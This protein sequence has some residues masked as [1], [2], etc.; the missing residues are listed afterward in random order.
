M[1]NASTASGTATARNCGLPPL[2]VKQERRH[3]QQAQAAQLAPAAG[4]VKEASNRFADNNTT[5]KQTPHADSQMLRR[6]PEAE[7]RI[8]IPAAVND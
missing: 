1:R 7:V 6:L 3:P 8:G 2:L 5:Q 4:A